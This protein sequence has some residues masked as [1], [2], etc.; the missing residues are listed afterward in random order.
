MSASDQPCWRGIA[1]HSASCSLAGAVGS[2]TG[3]SLRECRTPKIFFRD[4]KT[5]WAPGTGRLRSRPITPACQA[6]S[7]YATYQAPIGSPKEHAMPATS[8]TSDTTICARPGCDAQMTIEESV[9][10]DGCGRICRG[11]DEDIYGP[12]PAWWDGIEPPY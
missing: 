6:A 12:R 7:E 2:A 8:Q 5:S 11:C 1:A 3:L 4:R 9:Y 10:V